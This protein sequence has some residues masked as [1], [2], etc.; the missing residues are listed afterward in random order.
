MD[1]LFYAKKTQ[2]FY[3]LAKNNL[4]FQ[5]EELVGAATVLSLADRFMA[6]LRNSKCNA[7]DINSTE[8]KDNKNM[9][10]YNI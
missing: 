5:A 10:M 2:Y 6:S 4:T 3:V 9:C 8:L 1:S 7:L